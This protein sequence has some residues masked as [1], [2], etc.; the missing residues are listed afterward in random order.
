MS[1]DTDLTARDLLVESFARVRELVSGYTENLGEEVATFRPD[2]QAN[3]A[4][5]LLWH[6]VRVQDDH[7]AEL[8]G[9]EQVWPT[10]RD[11]FELPFEPDATGYGQTAEEVG[12]VRIDGQTLAG[13]HADVHALTRRYL[14]T[15]DAAELSRVV[16]TRWD[17]PVTAAARL[18][19]VLG[20]TL[21]HLGQV[22]YVLG[23]AQRRPS[24][25]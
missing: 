24:A 19:S 4:A 23:L 6:L 9:A 14:D 17:P 12:R 20:D 16:D 8:A 7:V 15:V 22:G 13:Y 21:Q 5:W 18:V 2:D 10:W 3:T 11:R 25:G 1:A